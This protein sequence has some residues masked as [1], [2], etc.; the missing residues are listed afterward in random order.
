MKLMYWLRNQSNLYYFFGKKSKYA[1]YLVSLHRKLMSRC[2]VR[3]WI[4][5][6][7]GALHLG[8]RC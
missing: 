6:S 4:V 8:M 3:G 5:N 7:E 2:L 1:D